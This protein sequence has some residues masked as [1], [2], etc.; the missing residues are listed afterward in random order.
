MIKDISKY[1][2]KYHLFALAVLLLWL[3]TYLVNKFYFKIPV[4]NSMQEFILFINPLSSALL[5]FGIVMLVR[6]KYRDKLIFI[7]SVIASIV[8]YGNVLFHR[9]YNDFITLPVL[10]QTSNMGDL[11]SSVNELVNFT[12]IY[13]F[14]DVFI[15][16]AYMIFFRNKE[17]IEQTTRGVLVIVGLSLLTFMLNI[18]LSETERPQLLSRTFDREMLVKN[19]GTFNYHIYD[20]LI[21][22][23][24]KAQKAFADGEELEDIVNYI[25][26]EK[27]IVPNE[28]TGIANGK[29]VVFIA[30]ESLQEFVIGN[31]LEGQE[32]TPFL[33]SLIK[34]SYYFNNIYHQTAQGK[35]SDSEFVIDTSLYPLPSGAVFFTHAQ[36]TNNGLPSKLVEN[37]YNTNVFHANN[38][39]FW[40]REIMYKSLG[41]NK[42]YDLEYYDVTEENSI[43][44]G[45]KD[46]EFFDQSVELMKD[47]SEPYSAKLITLTNHF[48][49][50]LEKKDEIIHEWNSS[51]P[52]LNRYFTTVS[53]MDDALKELF[54]KL[55][56]E[57]MYENTIFVLYGDH[58]GIS[59]N[60]NEAMSQYL[61]KEITPFESVQ[62]QKVPL[63][64]HIPGQ[65]GALLEKVGGQIDIKPTLLNLLGIENSEIGLGTDLFNNEKEEYVIFRDGTFV[66]RD[67]VNVSGVCYNKEDGLEVSE[68]I[69]PTLPM[70]NLEIKDEFVSESK[71]VN[72]CEVKEEKVRKELN[73]SDKLIY[74]DLL[75]FE[76]SPSLVLD[77][78]DILQ[79][80]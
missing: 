13:F 36:N 69:N 49:F 58:Y 52:T 2:K 24:T 3:K 32:I 8:I 28:L 38:S 47:L 1:I 17:K 44:W 54:D 21:Q 57:G 34:D 64:I 12:D 30:M 45:L 20:V 62:L 73:Y 4:E 75:R 26:E 15:L 43:G 14:I 7:V 31:N 60:H 22:S 77:K 53:Y 46:K 70:G 67:Y 27:N 29:N 6:I 66:T 80:N 16:L 18:G 35:S 42:F 40:N 63:I 25:S 74:G 72:P 55:K 19:I 59:E 33:N 68:N 51:S 37:G 61:G 23:K 5:I 50:S 71:F 78:Y 79:D 76:K 11:G 56:A 9:F 10:F 41:Y 65:E 48:P 39:S